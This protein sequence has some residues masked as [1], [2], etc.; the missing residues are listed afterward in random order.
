MHQPSCCHHWL[1]ERTLQLQ[2]KDHKCPFCPLLLIFFSFVFKFIVLFSL[3]LCLSTSLHVSPPHPLPEP[4]AVQ[5]RQPGLQATGWSSEA[6]KG[7][8]VIAAEVDSAAGMGSTWSHTHKHT[9]APPPPPYCLLEKVISGVTINWWCNQVAPIVSDSSS[10]RQTVWNTQGGEYLLPA[11]ILYSTDTSNYS[12]D[13]LFSLRFAKS[14]L[15]ILSRCCCV[16]ADK[17]SLRLICYSNSCLS[18]YHTV[19]LFKMSILNRNEP[20]VSGPF[21][22]FQERRA[23]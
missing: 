10:Y 17:M 22:Q 12:P 2:D 23:N 13:S 1:L 15:L 18:E 4:G 5:P 14:A 16:C 11:W 21:I 6:M 20:F 9:H 3:H 8:Q 19:C 7:L